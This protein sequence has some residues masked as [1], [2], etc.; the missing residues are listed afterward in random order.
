MEPCAKRVHC[1]DL[2]RKAVNAARVRSRGVRRSAW[3][4]PA[5]KGGTRARE[6]VE[7]SLGSP[8]VCF[9]MNLS[10]PKSLRLSFCRS[11]SLTS[12]V[13]NAFGVN[14]AGSQD[15]NRS[16]AV[17]LAHVQADH[18]FLNSCKLCKAAPSTTSC[19][20]CSATA[21]PDKISRLRAKEGRG[22]GLAKRSLAHPGGPAEAKPQ[23]S[24]VPRLRT[25]L[26]ETSSWVLS[27]S[28]G[29]IFTFLRWA[30]KEAVGVNA[31]AETFS[32]AS[33][34]M[35]LCGFRR[36]ARARRRARETLR[37]ASAKRR[38]ASQ[39]GH[40]TRR[41]PGVCRMNGSQPRRWQQL[42]LHA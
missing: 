16:A 18:G 17:M 33:P 13:N 36:P 31:A 28:H 12:E 4:P 3:T 27:R 11:Q 2:P 42:L 14:K 5:E 39:A 34:A 26:T 9:S 30:H 23:H 8:A 35:G 38:K 21:L 29:F 24:Q 20:V 40:N 41:P 19:T 25:G 32:A 7:E 10:V 37:T 22:Q 6:R 1:S 15:S